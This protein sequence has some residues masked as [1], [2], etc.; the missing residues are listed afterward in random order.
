MLGHD[1][2][3]RPQQGTVD[4]IQAAGICSLAS[5]FVNPTESGR[6]F[7]LKCN[8]HLEL[9]LFQNVNKLSDQL[10]VIFALN[11][12]YNVIQGSFAKV[13]Q[14][15]GVASRLMLGL[16]IN[17]D[18][19]PR[20]RTFAQQECLRRIGWH[21][22]HIDRMLAGGYDEYISCRAEIMKIPLPCDEAAFRG[23]RPVVAERLYDKPGNFPRTIN[24]HAFQVRLVDLRHRI[25]VYVLPPPLLLLCASQALADA[26]SQ[27]YKEALFGIGCELGPR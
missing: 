13:W 14:C 25:Q 7:G 8:N 9:Y 19:Q 2:L 12:T 26:Q 5:F 11:I 17:W 23:S 22:F 15:F 27:H 20:G 16:R 24:M 4:P 18:V 3:T 1:E 6:E 21:L 10:L